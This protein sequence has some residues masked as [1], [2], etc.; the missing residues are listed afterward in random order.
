[1]STTAP[2]PSAIAES[3]PLPM[4]DVQSGQD[5]GTVR[6]LASAPPAAQLAPV[7]RREIRLHGQ[8]VRFLEKI[9]RPSSFDI[10]E[11]RYPQYC[12]GPR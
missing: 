8:Q 6:K 11:S 10:Q 5:R 3:A 12:P 7:T 2:N 9:S 1:V 4:Y